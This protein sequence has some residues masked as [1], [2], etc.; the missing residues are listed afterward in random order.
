M[1]A[2]EELELE[3]RDRKILAAKIYFQ[4]SVFDP[5]IEYVLYFNYSNQEYED[6]L[7]FMDRDYH[8]GFGSQILFGTIWFGD[9][10][11]ERS[12]Y[13][14]SEWWTEK[15]YPKLPRRSIE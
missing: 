2:K 15:S 5:K 10:W 9:S 14:G 1:N 3:V 4:Y 6:F 12:T 13:D 8:D 11:L 7:K